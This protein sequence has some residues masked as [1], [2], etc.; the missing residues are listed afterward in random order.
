[1]AFYGLYG[2]TS[3][4]FLRVARLSSHAPLVYDTVLAAA[5]FVRYRQR[6]YCASSAT[7]LALDLESLD[8]G[9]RRPGA[10]PGPFQG[11]KRAW[12]YSIQ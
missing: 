3:Y 9:Q 2:S 8:T 4:L 6:E 10:M 1:M 5:D 11:L 12:A 7:F